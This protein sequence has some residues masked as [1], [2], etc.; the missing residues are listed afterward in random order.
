MNHQY[1]ISS[2]DD[3][4]VL[5]FG[6]T[7]HKINAYSLAASLIA[8]A[9]AVRKAN[10]Q[11]NPGYDVEIVVEALEDGSFRVILQAIYKAA[12]NIFSKETLKTIAISI[13]AS[14]IYEKAFSPQPTITINTDEVIIES[15][16]EKL[17]VPRQ[18]YE[19]AEIAKKDDSI[20]SS[21]NKIFEAVNSDDSVS[22]FGI[23]HNLQDKVPEITIPKNRIKEVVELTPDTNDNNI[24]IIEE[25]NE[26]LEIVKAILE[27]GSRKW[28]FLWRGI[29]IS[30]P[31]LD[32]DF[33]NRFFNHDIR[34]APGD[35]LDVKLKIT[36]R[37]LP[38]IS[39]YENIKYEVISVKSH[40]PRFVQ[41]KL[42]MENN[43]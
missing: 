7:D 42:K 19:Q 12:G 6:T 40:T 1:T 4:I 13:V 25:G 36:Q 18:I 14:I 32:D 10:K 24:N 5:Y 43:N 39:V 30:A 41:G 28:E 31:V 29:R 17:V 22:S 37:K 16:G 9:D 8:F 11:I 3:K 27:R 21:V 38:D 15:N 33:Y 2:H 34:I 26:K 35:I 23:T 20:Q